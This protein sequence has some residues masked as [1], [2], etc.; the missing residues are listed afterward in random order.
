[1]TTPASAARCCDWGCVK[2]SS[3]PAQYD[4]S[5][6]LEWGAVEQ[7]EGMSRQWERAA[8][9]KHDETLLATRPPPGDGIDHRSDAFL[10]RL[11][12]WNNNRLPQDVLLYIWNRCDCKTQWALAKAT[13]TAVRSTEDH[14]LIGVNWRLPKIPAPPSV[15]GWL[16]FKAKYHCKCC[17]LFLSV[18]L[19]A[20]LFV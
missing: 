6:C 4:P 20:C 10:R 9:R 19:C 14:K 15:E 3:P 13:R 2:C 16:V 17:P 18:C 1:M 5:T 12:T 7:L 11:V 8:K